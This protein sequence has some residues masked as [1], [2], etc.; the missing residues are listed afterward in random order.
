PLLLLPPAAETDDR[1]QSPAGERELPLVN[2]RT[3]FGLTSSHRR[4]DLVERQESRRDAGRPELQG[5]VRRR[6]R[7]G[8]SDGNCPRSDLLPG[9]GALRDDNR[10]IAIPEGGAVRK[11]QLAVRQIRVGV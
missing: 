7:A 3:G 8:R 9:H 6:V 1:V 5:Q 2:Q 11:E 10:S 4:K